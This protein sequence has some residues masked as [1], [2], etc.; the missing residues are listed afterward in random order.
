MH[1]FENLNIVLTRTQMQM[2]TDADASHCVTTKALQGHS[3]GELKIAK[4]IH[5]IGNPR[6]PL[7]LPS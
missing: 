3:P 1:T 5:L 4:I 2:L 7:Q 6:C